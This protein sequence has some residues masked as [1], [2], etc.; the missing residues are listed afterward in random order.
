M[1]IDMQSAQLKIKHMTLVDEALRIRHEE[2][3]ALQRARIN[4]VASHNHFPEKAAKMLRRSGVSEKRIAK[5]MHRNETAFE[6]E[7]HYALYR[8]LR[9]HRVNIVRTHAR[10]CHLARAYM[11]GQSYRAVENRTKFTTAQ[12]RAVAKAVASTCTRFG[13]VTTERSVEA[14]MGL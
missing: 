9:D 13:H 2:R 3:K 1:E 6:D 10:T 11:R 14:W 4:R 12:Q 8:S 7:S 5:I